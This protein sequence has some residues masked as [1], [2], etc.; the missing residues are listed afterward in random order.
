MVKRKFNEERHY[1]NKDASTYDS[2]VGDHRRK[3]IENLK[4]TLGL[5]NDIR[6]ITTFINN[7]NNNNNNNNDSNKIII[8]MII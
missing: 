8:M 1:K 5:S 3:M 4:K 2:I 7:N 6:S